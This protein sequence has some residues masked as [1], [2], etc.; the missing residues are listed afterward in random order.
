V[1]EARDTR[2][3]EESRR[4]AARLSRLGWYHSIEL[5]DGGVIEGLQSLDQQRQRLHQFPIPEDLTGKRVLDIGAWDG[6]FSFEMERRGAE[7]LAVD[8]ARN[9]RL[10][11]ARQLLGSRIDYQ[12]AD[13]CRLTTKDVGTFDIVLFFGVLYHLKHPLLALENVCGMCRDMACIE[14]FVTDADPCEFP[15]MEFYETTELR[16]QADNWI[17]PNLSCLLAFCRTAGF[18]RVNFESVLSERAHV[19]GYR[20]WLEHAETDPAP[21]VLCVANSAR[22]DHTFVES[23]DDYLTFYFTSPLDDLKCD[24]VYPQIGPYGSRPIDVA[25]CGGGWQAACKLPP[26]LARGPHDAK[27][28][29]AHSPYSVPVRI[30]LGPVHVGSDTPVSSTLRLTRVADG[31]TLETGRVRVGE[32]SG[33]SVWAAGLP[34]DARRTSIR[35]RLNGTDLPANWIAAANGEEPRQINAALPSGL[36]PG[37]AT[38]TLVFEG[39]Q[40][41]PVRIELI[42]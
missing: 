40:S 30:V 38:V 21:E 19:T 3:I 2:F 14:S 36:E 18:A 24:N 10:L 26:G 34:A 1:S 22:Q 42:R 13:I 12:I 4:Q 16:G 27:I 25:R 20:H 37:I 23:A 31:A 8:A 35:L 41:A 29:T 39:E 11:E 32:N 6:W 9:T 7:V 15:L 28:R 5:P 33:M 17:G